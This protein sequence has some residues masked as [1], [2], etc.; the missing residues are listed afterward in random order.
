VDEF[1]IKVTV[2]HA[3]DVYQPAIFQELKKRK[4]PVVYG[5]IDSFAYKVE[6]KHED[7]RN[8]RI[9]LPCVSISDMNFPGCKYKI[10]RYNINELRKAHRRQFVIDV[11]YRILT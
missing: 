7:W 9:E 8:I 11:R 4:I 2:K 6:L 10:S 5:P 3:M 1:K